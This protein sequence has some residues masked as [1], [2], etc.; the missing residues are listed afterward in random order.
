MA[1]FSEKFVISAAGFDDVIDITTKVENILLNSNVK[2][3]LVNIYTNSPGVCIFTYNDKK[4]SIFDI[5]KS[6]NRVFSDE[7]NYKNPNIETNLL[8]SL[9]MQIFKQNV[10][11]PYSDGKIELNPSERI[12]L[13][14][15]SKNTYTKQIIV[16]MIY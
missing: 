5:L 2:D 16:T 12:I 15:F 13:A 14:D 4:E 10:T 9:K 3:A 1:I 8:T 6:I 11:L 7:I